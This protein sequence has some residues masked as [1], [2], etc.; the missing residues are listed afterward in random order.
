M[1]WQIVAFFLV[2]LAIGYFTRRASKGPKSKPRPP[3]E[4][5]KKLVKQGKPREAKE[6]F[7]EALGQNQAEA[8][9]HLG[10]LYY[11]K[12][13][14]DKDP[15]LTVALDY[16]KK[17][18]ANG[19]TDCSL[20]IADIYNFCNIPEHNIPNKRLAK[21]IY[22]K[23]SKTSKNNEVRIEATNKLTD[24]RREESIQSARGRQTD[25]PRPAGAIADMPRV[26]RDNPI[27]PRQPFQHP[28]LPP[29][30][31]DLL[32]EMGILIDQ[33]VHIPL[34]EPRIRDDSQNAHD[35]GVQRGMRN[36]INKLRDLNRYNQYAKT[37]DKTYQEIKEYLQ[38]AP[39]L[40]KQNR[41]KA[42][43]T[44]EKMMKTGNAQISETGNSEREIMAMVW[45]RIHA[46][47][48]K[49]NIN[50]LKEIFATQLADA[51]PAGAPVCPSGR[52]TRVLSSLN[53][54]DAD[55]E[56]GDLKP[57]WALKEELNSLA[58]KTREQVLSSATQE[59]RNAYNSLETTPEG[60]R[61]TD[62]IKSEIQRKCNQDYGMTGLLTNQEI[63]NELKPILD[64]V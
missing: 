33:N 34:P 32:R 14:S 21:E 31:D 35:S 18:T 16:Y 47:A 26:D 37:P 17:A 49:K 53:K 10:E 50:N 29:V 3:I 58:A 63:Q 9:Y 40:T 59:Q 57:K 42:L 24:L 4:E 6:K 22:N 1:I 39:Q 43:N 5:G 41:G 15:Y 8:L 38:K 7:E 64:A 54:V 27:G 62:H 20:R 28:H 46:S 56:I 19:Y 45:T 48:N 30:G 36:T 13:T 55:P 25:G 44:L 12:C 60:E 11:S 52:V 2:I 51:S 23:L 61:L